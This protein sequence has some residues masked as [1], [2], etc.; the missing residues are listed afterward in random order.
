MGTHVTS[1]ADLTSEA[2]EMDRFGRFHGLPEN[3]QLDI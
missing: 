1:R 2:L 3:D